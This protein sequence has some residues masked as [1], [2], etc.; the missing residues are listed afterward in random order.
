MQLIDEAVQQGARCARA[1]EE[2]GLSVRTVQRWRVVAAG[3]ACAGRACSATEQAGRSAASGRARCGQPGGLRESD[4]PPD[5]T[6]TG[7]RRDLSGVGIDVLP[8]AESGGTGPASGSREAA[9][10][11]YAH[12]ALRRGPESGVVLGYHLDAEH[13]QGP[14][15][16]LVHD[17]GHLQ[18]QAGDER[19]M[20]GGV[21]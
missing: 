1:C 14:I 4:A 10:T 3:Q 8:G 20:G 5:R 2:L 16:L 7:R 12:D 17:E 9:T 15:L 6:E 13:G 11:T 21:G 18:P 19:G